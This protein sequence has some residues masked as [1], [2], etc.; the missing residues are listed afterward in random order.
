MPRSRDI[1]KDRAAVIHDAVCQ[2]I[3]SLC[4]FS[5]FIIDY[6]YIERL[7]CISMHKNIICAAINYIIF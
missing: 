1:R 7:V 4:I 6:A 2:S 5:I 3:F